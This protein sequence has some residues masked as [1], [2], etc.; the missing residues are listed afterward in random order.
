VNYAGIGRAH[1]TGRVL[2]HRLDEWIDE[3]LVVA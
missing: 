3:L 1:L 2:R